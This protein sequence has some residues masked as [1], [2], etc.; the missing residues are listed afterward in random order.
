MKLKNKK[1]YHEPT[2]RVA[3]PFTEKELKSMDDWGFENRIRD[4]TKVIRELVSI[5][6]KAVSH[7]QLAR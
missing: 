5:G 2:F 4:R 6:L 7:E 3:A 1:T